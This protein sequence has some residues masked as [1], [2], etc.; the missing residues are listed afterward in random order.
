MTNPQLDCACPN[1]SY[2]KKHTTECFTATIEYLQGAA[3]A[4]EDT[5]QG[6][7][8]MVDELQS[9]NHTLRNELTAARLSGRTGAEAV[10]KELFDSI[11]EALATGLNWMR[12]Y[13]SDVS[14][15]S[16]STEV[17]LAQARDA[18]HK[19]IDALTALR[20]S[21]E[22]LPPLPPEILADALQDVVHTD[23]GPVRAAYAV[24]S[25]VRHCTNYL[26][27]PGGQSCCT[28]EAGHSG[29]CLF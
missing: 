14:G 5:L 8:A 19:A 26:T 1:G 18:H 27:Y 29:S 11:D 10:T 24:K 12:A 21:D 15:I 9:E 6:L 16:S 22:P 7:R 13:D 25:E 4:D 3:K 17:S 28:R 20:R 23:S 2:G